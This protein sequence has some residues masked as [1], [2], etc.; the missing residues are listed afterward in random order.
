MNPLTTLDLT[1]VAEP[2]H[3]RILVV[4]QDRHVTE[5]A[6]RLAG[7]PPEARRFLGTQTI[8]MPGVMI[9][10]RPVRSKLDVEMLRGLEFHLILGIEHVAQEL[11]AQLRALVR[12]PPI[13]DGL[14]GRDGTAT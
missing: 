3:F 7:A 13:I 12:R 4:H 14:P 1:P 11:Q 9:H 10:F 6:L 2:K 5:A 8:E